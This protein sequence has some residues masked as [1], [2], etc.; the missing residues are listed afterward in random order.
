MGICPPAFTILANVY[1]VSRTRTS[2]YKIPRVLSSASLSPIVYIFI[3]PQGQVFITRISLLHLTF[4]E[5][6]TMSVTG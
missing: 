2:S 3:S 5:I 1:F 6:T 4:S